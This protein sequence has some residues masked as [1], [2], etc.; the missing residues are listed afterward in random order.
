MWRDARPATSCSSKSEE[1]HNNFAL[2]C[3]LPVLCLL[4]LLGTFS[5]CSFNACCHAS[6]SAAHLLRKRWNDPVNVMYV[7]TLKYRVWNCLFFVPWNRNKHSEYISKLLF[8]KYAT[9]AHGF[10]SKLLPSNEILWKSF[11][12]VYVVA[13]ELVRTKHISHQGHV[14]TKRDA[15]VGMLQ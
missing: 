15:Q 14:S 12:S 5:Y 9:G 10:F 1:G 13:Q 4:C 2:H 11:V 8:C 7:V 6:C 3:A